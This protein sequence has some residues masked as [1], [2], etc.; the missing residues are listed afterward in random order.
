MNLF[1]VV[2]VL[3]IVFSVVSKHKYKKM[4]TEALQKLGFANWNVVSYFDEYV[5][6]KSRQALEKYDDVKFFKENEGFQ[7]LHLL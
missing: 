6:V 4:E 3:I 5:T 1:I 7:K 2:I